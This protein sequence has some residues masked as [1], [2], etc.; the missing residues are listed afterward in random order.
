M[1][2]QKRYFLMA[3]AK[4]ASKKYG[5]PYTWLKEKIDNVYQKVGDKLFLYLDNI[6]FAISSYNGKKSLEEL[7][8][9]SL[10]AEAFQ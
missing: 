3:Y 2:E 1:C 9:T 6:S 7:I 4:E 10:P 8:I 5:L